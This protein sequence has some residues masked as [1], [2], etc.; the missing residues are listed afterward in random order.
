MSINTTTP[1]EREKRTKVKQKLPELDLS[2]IVSE[3][4]EPKRPKKPQ[5]RRKVN[6]SRSRS[7]STQG[8]NARVR[9][10][11][12]AR[13]LKSEDKNRSVEIRLKS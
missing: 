11:S 9:S 6:L 13:T 1:F 7:K 3:E 5:S 8:G 12:A 2:R 4:K 10:Q